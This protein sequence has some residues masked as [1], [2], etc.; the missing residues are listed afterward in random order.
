MWEI[1]TPSIKLAENG[2]P[3]SSHL[4]ESLNNKK[5]LF[6]QDNGSA[7]LFI[8][9]NGRPWSTGQVLKQIDLANTLKRIAKNDRD[10]FYSGITA[11]LIKAEMQSNN[12]LITDLDLN[13]YSS[14]YRKPLRGTYKDFEIMTMGLPSSGGVIL[15]EMLN[16]LETLGIDTLG[17]NS[18]DYVHRLTE[19]ARRS[20]AD[21]AEHLGDPDFWD[22]PVKM[23]VDKH[24][25]ISRTTS[26]DLQKASKSTD[27][28]AGEVQS[29]SSET[30]HYSIV[31]REGNCVAVTT[32]LNTGFGSGMIVDGA[33]F[34][35]NNQMDDFSTKPGVPNYYGLIGNKA[36][37]IQPGKRPLSSMTPT[38]IF[39]NNTPFLIIGTPGGST[40]INTVLQVFLNVALHGMNVSDAVAAPRVHSQW[41]PDTIMKE[42]ESV[43]VSVESELRNM[44]HDIITHPWIT[45]GSA[46]GILIGPDGYY[47]GADPR[48]DNAAQG[49]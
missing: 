22:V 7:A 35:L 38:I 29:E 18:S 13:Q 40:I 15:I 41:F 42:S 44:G 43:S 11:E 21:R 33:G 32:T 8:R 12:G 48:S 6:E 25:A 31:D 30:T 49:Y 5:S 37:A 24:Y 39:D 16:M 20:Y 4:A 17:W 9:H 23:L 28:Y 46:N 36:N 10:G 45:F 34:L 1:L 14:I 27:I 3:I 2:F 47:G 26:I 19:V